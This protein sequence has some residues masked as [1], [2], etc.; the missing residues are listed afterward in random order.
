MKTR[1]AST[2]RS[3]LSIVFFVVGCRTD[4]SG[5]DS[6][7]ARNVVSLAENR[8]QFCQVVRNLGQDGF[9]QNYRYDS[10][11]LV[12]KW[13]DGFGSYLPQYD[14]AGVLNRARYMLGDI[15]LASIAYEY[16]AGK[17]VKEVW[18]NG[19]T[20][21]IDDILVNT[22]NA[23]GQLTRRESVPFGVFATFQYDALGNAYQVDVMTNTGLLLL[24]NTYTFQ[25]Q[26]KNPELTLRGLPYG[27]QFLN[28]VFNPRR[29]TSAKAV[30]S[31]LEGN[32]VT[33]FD[34]D[35]QRSVLVA[36]QQQFALFQNFYDKLSGTY[37]AQTWSYANCNGN[38]FP[39]DMPGSQLQAGSR[40]AGPSDFALHGSM[41]SVKQQIEALRRK[42]RP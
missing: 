6:N 15:T 39:P 33:L 29:Q 28:H 9:L 17:I 22:W 34:Q 32:R 3:L 12:S 4:S 13:D 8:G 2:W 7:P 1:S 27:P 30:V 41:K 35:P 18:F 21:L 31:D 38:N 25:A 5:P 10:R 26:V 24:S 11:G 37:Y 36:G 42:L 20:G 16:S 14:A 23:N 19:A 40:R